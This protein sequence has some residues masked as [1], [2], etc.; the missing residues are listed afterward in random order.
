M[1]LKANGEAIE[2]PKALYYS[3]VQFDA[4]S[5]TTLRGYIT[6][7]F[8]TKRRLW[9][10]T[11]DPLSIDSEAKVKH[12]ENFFTSS[13]RAISLDNVNYRNVFL[14]AEDM[15]IEW[16]EGSKLLIQVTFQASS[17]APDDTP[18]VGEI[19]YGKI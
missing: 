16:L 18:L 14:K 10:I 17:V 15:P 2:Y 9:S 13:N 1:Y 11:I 4:D 5:S 19:L 3:R 8:R 7:K 12:L 6:Q